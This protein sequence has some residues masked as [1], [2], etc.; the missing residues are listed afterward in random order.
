M[1]CGGGFFTPGAAYDAVW[2]S[3]KPMTGNF[4]SISSTMGSLSVFACS[5]IG[6]AAM[7][8]FAPTTTTIPGL[9]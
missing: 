1:T 4:S 6:S 5:M 7:T 2:D 3:V 9:C 8:I